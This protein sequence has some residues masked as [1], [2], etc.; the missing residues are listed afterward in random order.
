LNWVKYSF[1]LFQLSLLQLLITI[2]PVAAETKSDWRS[3]RVTDALAD[4][5]LRANPLGRREA[6]TLVNPLGRSE[7]K[8][9]PL[10]ISFR[11]AHR[12]NLTGANP[13]QN[14]PPYHQVS[15]S[16]ADLLAQS[17]LTP[18]TG[19]E[20]ILKTAAGR[21]KLVPLI[22]PEGN[23]LVIDLLDATNLQSWY[24]FQPTV[25]ANW[26][27]MGKFLCCLPLILKRSPKAWRLRSKSAGL[28]QS[29]SVGG[30]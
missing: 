1:F 28:S 12:S 9:I 21:Q 5:S 14:I 3:Q 6:S 29:Q 18:V 27:S 2:N 20:A 4:E 16:A 10:R 23:N 19:L 15:T 11:G 7:C 26:L 17:N 24:I 30:A 25:T 22:L 13:V 8:S